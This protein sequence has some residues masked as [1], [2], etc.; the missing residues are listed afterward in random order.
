[1]TKDENTPTTAVAARTG[2][3]IVFDPQGKL[4]FRNYAAVLDFTG[5]LVAAGMAPKGKTKEQC[6]ICIAFGLPL[7]M[8]V[9]ASI[10]NIAVINGM[11]CVWGDALV[12]LVMASGLLEDMKVEYLPSV[13]ECGAVK[14]TVKRRGIREPFVGMFSRHMAEVAGLWGKQ[15]PWTQYPLRMML[16]RARAFAFRDGFA[17]VLKGLKVAEEV[18][19]VATEEAERHAPAS[20]RARVSPPPYGKE[21]GD[22]PAERKR[23]LTAGDLIN[24]A[25][26]TRKAEAEAPAPAPDA[27]EEA[28]PSAPEAGAA[29]A[30]AEADAPAPDAA[31]MTEEVL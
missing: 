22:R 24:G 1:M 12:G 31:T 7:G 19:D 15:G 29:D 5:Q 30:A 23:P 21:A 28:V 26:R 25:A 27:E 11:P 10:Q 13:K 16:N 8:D 3:D 4:Q 20:R 14:V 18:L 17:D 6:A 9:L 2:T